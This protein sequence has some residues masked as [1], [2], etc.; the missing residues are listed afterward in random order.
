[1]TP[2]SDRKPKVGDRVWVKL[3]KLGLSY[4]GRVTEVNVGGSGLA[5][6]EIDG[7]VTHWRLYPGLF[8]TAWGF[9]DPAPIPEAPKP[10]EPPEVGAV[11]DVRVRVIEL[12]GYNILT[13]VAVDD[14]PYTTVFTRDEFAHATLVSRPEKPLQ[15]GGKVTYRVDARATGE[16]RGICGDY[17]WVKWLPGDAPVTEAVADLRRAPEGE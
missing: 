15:V 1:M 8:G 9:L 16:V 2:A 12:S 14:A 11:Y 10:Y 13:R 3:D 5:L 17:A 7:G 6:G 4:D